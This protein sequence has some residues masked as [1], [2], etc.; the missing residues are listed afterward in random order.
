MQEVYG[1]VVHQLERSLELCHKVKEQIEHDCYV[2][3]DELGGKTL[4]AYEEIRQSHKNTI[5]K[6]YK[7]LLALKKNMLNG[8][9]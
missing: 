9:V 3:K 2:K 1:M 4:P 6:I 8:Q 5:E 7:Q